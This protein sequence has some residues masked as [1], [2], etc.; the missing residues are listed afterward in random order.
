MPGK[1]CHAPVKLHALSISHFT[2]CTI[3]TFSASKQS[4]A[5]DEEF[6]LED[7]TPLLES[8]SDFA[9]FPG[10]QN[11]AVVKDFLDRF[12]L[13]LIISSLQTKTDVPGLEKT[14]VACL[15]RIFKTKY[16]ASLIPQY[17]SFVQLGLKADSQLVRCLACKTVACLL[18]N[19]ND[20]TI[21][22]ARLIID[23]DI[24]PLL[25]DCLI[26]G[27]EQVAT[28]ST[29]AITKLAGFP[30]GMEVIFPANNDDITHLRNLSAR[31]S[32]LGR[33][34]VLSLVVKLFSVSPDVASVVYKSNLL[35][36]LEA[37]VSNTDD[38]LVTLSI[39]ELFYELAVV[40][41]GVEF[42][43]RTTIIQLLSSMISNTMTDVILRSRAMMIS[44]RL[45]AKENTYVFIDE[46]CAK[47]V[48]SA[49]DGRL[50]FESQDLNECEC[51][52]EAL[53]QIGLSVPGATLL[54]SMSP[55]PARHV[56]DAAFDRQARGKQLAALHSLGNI[57]G[58]SQSESNKVLN[59]DA[60]EN[61]RRLIYETASKTSKLTPSGLFL[62]VLQQ[63]SEIRLAAYRMITGLVA[64]PWCLM[65]ICSKQEIVN[66]IT[67]P[68][69]ETTKIGMEARYNCCKAIQ[70]AF[71]SASKLSS[72][73]SLVG[74]ATKLQEA[75]SR[76]PY[77]TG[78][79][80]EAQPAVMTAERF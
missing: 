34:R 63:D 49:I 3:P 28:A 60:E 68:I 8:A 7:P 77:L 10:V 24:Y 76:G 66:I 13:P 19:V 35:G 56:I 80:R 22:P 61:L 14:L 67:D 21:S 23:S 55:S 57:S 33:V 37:E 43:S 20:K 32:S 25:L 6:S 70:K 5:M 54:L 50:S 17:M 52:L 46:S 16:G 74:I 4:Q 78:K 12:P 38:T 47:T 42:L 64:R 44:G 11:D 79:H 26:N 18:E 73:P 53:G 71:M 59:A 1:P 58:E 29:E 9:Y 62:S 15:E 36:L 39:L 69:T 51:A 40:Q 48:M 41:H 65:E 75:V 30:K 45:L 27:N 72:N 2:T 31:C